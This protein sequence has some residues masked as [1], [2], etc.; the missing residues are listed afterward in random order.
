[1]HSERAFDQAAGLR[2]LLSR[3]AAPVW[4]FAGAQA[5]VGVTGLVIGLAGLLSSQG[6]DVLVLDEHLSQDNVG[7]R[8][9]LR[10]RFD[11]LDAVRGDKR[12]GDVLLEAEPGFRVLSMA[13]TLRDFSRL[14]PRDLQSFA[15]L[16]DQISQAADVIL[17]DAANRPRK[18]PLSWRKA[19]EM[20]VVV[21]DCSATGIKAAYALIK[22][23]HQ[24][25]GMCRVAV[26]MNRVREESEADWMLG[27]LAQVAGEHMKVRVDCLGYIPVDEQASGGPQLRFD[28][29]AGLAASL[30]STHQMTTCIRQPV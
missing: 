19:A 12:L 13:R 17:V 1:M 15:H 9:S 6:L 5:D 28:T 4:F 30:G 3:P 10:P 14:N 24:E 25:D 26:V 8:L 22:R 7:N 18:V 23:L 11:L 16:L 27:N 21:M 20:P 29:L 2:R